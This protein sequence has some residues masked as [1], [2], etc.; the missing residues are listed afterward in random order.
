VLC[1][2]VLVR[3][4]AADTLKTPHFLIIYPVSD[5]TLAE[6]IATSMEGARD[7]LTTELGV[8]HEYQLKI[9]LVPGLS[10]G[11]NAQYL[12]HDKTIEMLTTEGMTELLG[13]RRPPMQFIKAILWHE[14]VHFLQHRIMKRFIHSRDALWFIEGTAN[15]LGTLRFI[16]RDSPGAVW[17]EGRTILARRQLP[18]LEDLNRYH[19]TKQYPTVAY[20]FSTEAVEFLVNE[21]GIEALRQINLK[22]GKG[23]ELRRCIPDVTGI[24]L[25]TFE[26]R[27]HKSLKR[28]Y[29]SKIRKA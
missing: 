20:F 28:V 7:T 2:A 6:T 3:L 26:T 16:G 18:K 25:K 11:H 24:D 9:K 13:G 23:K 1:L 10:N 22:L 17:E 12:P 14:Y 4:A 5:A 19:E 21:W 8:T 29:A 15:Y 27:W